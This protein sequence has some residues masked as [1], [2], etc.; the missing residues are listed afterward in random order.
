[1]TADGY[2]YVEY[3]YHEV[4]GSYLPNAWGLYDMHGNVFEWCLDRY[5]W[6]LGRDAVSDPMGPMSGNGRVIRGGSH[7]SVARGCRSAARSNSSSNRQ[8]AY[9]GFR[10]V[11]SGGL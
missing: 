4:A 9:V 6:N 7:G 10:L 3:L 11:C 2:W 1:M 8:D 5:T